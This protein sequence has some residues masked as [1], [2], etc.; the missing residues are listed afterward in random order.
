MRTVLIFAAIIVCYSVNLNGQKSFYSFDSKSYEYF[1][2]GDYKRLRKTAD[3]M[4][5]Q[6]IDYYYLRVRLGI[7]EYNKQLYSRAFVDFK[8]ALTFNSLD[9]ISR[10]YIY[11]SYLLSGRSHDAD[12][13]TA[14]LS[15]GQKN[16]ALRRQEI[17]DA[18]TSV[19]IGSSVTGYDVTL[20]N[21]NRLEYEAIKSSYNISAGIETGISKHLKATIAY[22][23]F[24]KTGTTYTSVDSTGAKLNFN[25]NQVYAKLTGFVFSGWEFNGFGDFVFYSEKLPV[26]RPGV[27]GSVNSTKTE[28]LG[29]FGI[30]KNG[31]KI[32]MGINIS[33]SNFGNSDQFRSEGYLTFLPL[34]NLNLYLTA[35]GMYQNDAIWGNTYQFNGEFGIKILKNLWLESGIMKG[36]SFLYARSQGYS[37]NNSYL[38][39]ANVIYCNFILITRK[40]LSLTLTPYFADNMSYSWNLTSYY[41]TDKTTDSSYGVAIKL[42]YKIK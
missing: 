8:K 37:V 26:R 16:N 5:S 9:T 42:T 27:I 33:F 12:L 40:K 18:Q 30:S 10:E 21:K 29:G 25:Q 3:S 4:F 35:G 31:W 11:Y 22:T 24:G 32:R 34:G 28:F 1:L 19:F 36:N 2:R 41:R 17:S 39:P 20:F 7:L 13:Y 23:N 14:F 6:G 38:I 15:N